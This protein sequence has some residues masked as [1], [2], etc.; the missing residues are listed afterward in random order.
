MKLFPHVT[1][2]DSSVQVA[3]SGGHSPHLVFWLCYFVLSFLAVGLLLPLSRGG[4]ELFVAGGY[5]LSTTTA[6]VLRRR[7]STLPLL[8]ALAYAMFGAVASFASAFFAPR[9]LEHL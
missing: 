5:V 8:W 7:S 3:R 2:L 4:F 9:L 1:E 6:I